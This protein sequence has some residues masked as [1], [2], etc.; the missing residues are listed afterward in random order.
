[1][2]LICEPCTAGLDNIPD[3]NRMIFWNYT[4]R[5]LLR[6][7][8]DRLELEHSDSISRRGASFLA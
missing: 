3:S 8:E 2:E 7:T 4:N 5:K 1:M 6:R